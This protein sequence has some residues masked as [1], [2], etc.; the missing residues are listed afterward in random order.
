MPILSD[1]STFQGTAVPES[2]V[3]SPTTGVQRTASGETIDQQGGH[4]PDHGIGNVENADEL[5]PQAMQYWHASE[6]LL[7]SMCDRC[8][9][10]EPALISKSQQLEEEIRFL[11][12][13]EVL[14]VEPADRSKAERRTKRQPALRN[15]TRRPEC[16]GS[17]AQAIPD[18]ELGKPAVSSRTT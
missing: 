4:A 18:V 5:E 13:E 16:P 9:G 11:A 3:E 15:E 8:T 10:H 2:R 6:T 17:R 14:L 12:I 1:D 7:A